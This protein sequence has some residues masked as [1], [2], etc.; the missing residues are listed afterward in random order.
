MNNKTC[1]LLLTCFAAL[2]P[3]G[4]YSANAPQAPTPQT[5]TPQTPTPQTNVA[6]KPLAD[7]AS[8]MADLDKQIAEFKAAR[9]KAKRQAYIAGSKADQFMG[10]NWVDY[11][12][13]LTVQEMYQH[14]VQEL[15]K[16][17][18]E[19]EKQKKDLQ[20]KTK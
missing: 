19:L 6:P 12:R 8:K 16:K 7:T 2:T 15:D 9:L 17:I 13:A 14:Q 5:S 1:A 20:A 4:A 3:V 18:A 11:Q 10:Q